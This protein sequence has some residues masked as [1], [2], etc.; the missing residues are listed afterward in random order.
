[1]QPILILIN[2]QPVQIGCQLPDGITQRSLDL[3]PFIQLQC[4]QHEA[5]LIKAW[6]NNVL[7]RLDTEY[8]AY[9]GTLVKSTDFRKF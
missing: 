3:N 7:D 2:N 4:E 8:A 1:M 6:L 5:A 9:N